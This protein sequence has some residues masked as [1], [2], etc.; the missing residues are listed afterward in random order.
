MNT[1]AQRRAENAYQKKSVKRAVVKFY[2]G[3]EKLYEWVKSQENMSGYFKELAR[4]DMEQG[5]L[6]Q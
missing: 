2:P 4:R 1:S 3:D 6:G 5:G